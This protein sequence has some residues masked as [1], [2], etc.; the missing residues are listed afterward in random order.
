MNGIRVRVGITSVIDILLFVH[1]WFL[2]VSWE[3]LQKCKQIKIA[4]E[5]KERIGEGTKG[6]EA[7]D[8]REKKEVRRE[9]R[10][11]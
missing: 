7:K 11:K 4:M 9:R 8:R 5:K 6:G 1:T 10:R 3:P 2:F